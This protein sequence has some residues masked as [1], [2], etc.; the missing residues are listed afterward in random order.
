VNTLSHA[1]TEVKTE[2]AVTEPAGAARL[3]P[4]MTAIPV[5]DIWIAETVTLEDVA[6]AARADV[7]QDGHKL[8]LRQTTGDAP[9][10][11]RH[12]V[13]DAGPPT[14]SGSS[15]TCAG[16]RGEAASKQTACAR[17]SSAFEQA[18]PQ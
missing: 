9:L 18:P 3:A 15:S 10:A 17:R 13:D 4:F 2:H 6:S 8:V 5:T 7:V 14:R 16:T 11:F 12:K 1:L